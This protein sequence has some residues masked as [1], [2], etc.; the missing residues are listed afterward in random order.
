M[1]S[2]LLWVWRNLFW[3]FQF[4]SEWEGV[5]SFY[6]LWHSF[7]FYFHQFSWFSCQWER[8]QGWCRFQCCWEEEHRSLIDWIFFLFFRSEDWTSTHTISHQ[9]WCCWCFF[10]TE[11][12]FLNFYHFQSWRGHWSCFLRN[13]SY[14]W[15]FL[16][17]GFIGFSSWCWG[18]GKWYCGWHQFY[19]NKFC[20]HSTKLMTFFSMHYHLVLKLSYE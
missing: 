8:V 9:Y 13:P 10:P 5:I 6:P 3:R 11:W 4:S 17:L 7:D 12:Y 14:D 2:L 18:C 15:G 16:L 20:T 1:K 19:M